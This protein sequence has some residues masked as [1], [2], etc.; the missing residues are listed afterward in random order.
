M[1]MI[2][3]FLFFVLLLPFTS[4]KIELESQHTGYRVLSQTGAEKELYTTTISNNLICTQPKLVSD[5]K[6]IKQ[7]VC[8]D[9]KYNP[10]KGCQKEKQ[11]DVV[12]SYPKELNTRDEKGT[13][14]LTNQLFN[15]GQCIQ[16]NSP[17]LYRF[18]KIGE[19]SI[20]LTGDNKYNSVDKNVTQ[21]TK[22]AHLNITTDAPYN[23]LIGYWNFDADNTTTVFDWSDSG[24]DGTKQGGY[25]TGTTGGVYKYYGDFNGINSK[26]TFTENDLPVGGTARS[27]SAWIRTSTTSMFSPVF[28]SY[29][30]QG[31]TQA[32]YFGVANQSVT[33]CDLYNPPYTGNYSLWLGTDGSGTNICGTSK[34]N[35]DKWHH[36]VAVY[37][38]NTG[39]SNNWTLW[40]DTIMEKTFFQTTNT[41]SS[42]TGVIG[43]AINDVETFNGFIDE[44]MVFNI[45]LNS[46][47]I[48]QIYQNKSQRFRNTGEMVF[49]NLNFGNN[50]TVNITIAQCQMTMDTN[51]TISINTQDE[52]GLDKNTCNIKN[53]PISGNR[54]SAN[55]T[56]RLI[57]NKTLNN[58]YSPIVFGNITLLDWQQYSD[59]APVVT[60]KSPATGNITGNTTVFLAGNFTDDWQLVNATLYLW[61]ATHTII[62]QTV[63]NISGTA[64]TSNVSVV[65]PYAGLFRWNY[66]AGDNASLYSFASSNFT[67]NYTIPIDQ[68]PLV[69]LKS[70]ANQNVSGDTSNSFAG[71]FTDDYGLINATLYVWNSAHTVTNEVTVSVTGLANTTN[72][73]VSIPVGGSY[74]WN[75][76]VTDNSSQV[77]FAS[78][79]FT[80]NITFA[81]TN[82]TCTSITTSTVKRAVPYV[83]LCNSLSFA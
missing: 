55:L 28:F 32:I 47:Q 57:A 60:L 3:L 6:T 34:I 80:I 12:Y 24:H 72:Q 2:Y 13:I 53:Y 45:S 73:T 33:E 30:T 58:F 5:S 42:S 8:E 15:K 22:Y 76:L 66:L 40:V 48:T 44:M 82:L 83:K 43:M 65:L 54:T 52:R 61:N 59:V 67:I 39:F 20:I 50:D 68:K 14:L 78:S 27:F 75:Y 25:Q 31:G 36:V 26:V 23:S 77:A 79:N 38:N 74:K 51:L 1:K 69:T 4:A 10:V 64:N 11:V 35:D 56:I 63:Y 7:K 62:N 49:S 71:N 17:N 41:V 46:S 81:E 29:G 9:V 18:L 37:N 21:E 19:S 16:I 70:P